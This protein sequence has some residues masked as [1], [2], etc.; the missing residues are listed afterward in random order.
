MGGFLAQAKEDRYDFSF[1]R[2]WTQNY[3]PHGQEPVSAGFYLVEQC[4]ISFISIQN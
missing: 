3:I 4:F 1:L 2:P